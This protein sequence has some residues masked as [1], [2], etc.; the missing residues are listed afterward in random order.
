METV[1]PGKH[2]ARLAPARSVLDR[3]KGG[4]PYLSSIAKSHR[5]VSSVLSDK[6]VQGSS[7]IEEINQSISPTTRQVTILFLPWELN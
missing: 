2:D 3:I 1:S 6:A 5:D 4:L 7:I